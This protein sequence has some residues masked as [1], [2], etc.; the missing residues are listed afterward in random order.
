MVLGDFRVNGKNSQI[1]PYFFMDAPI[2]QFQSP[3][4]TRSSSIIQSR[5]PLFI[6]IQPNSAILKV[7]KLST[8][9]EAQIQ[10][11]TLRFRDTLQP[12]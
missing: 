12:N 5:S 8:V 10:A 3:I 2:L 7:N 9:K 4:R 11:V 6:P 1:L